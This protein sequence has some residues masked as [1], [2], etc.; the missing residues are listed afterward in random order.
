MFVLLKKL[1]RYVFVRFFCD[2]SELRVIVL[3]MYFVFG[4]LFYIEG[5]VNWV[6]KVVGMVGGFEYIVFIIGMY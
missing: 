6:L 5:K 3:Y 4:F 2:M 1:V